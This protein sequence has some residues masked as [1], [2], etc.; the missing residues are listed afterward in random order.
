[1][2]EGKNNK[3]KIAITTVIVALIS[4]G[5]GFF[6]G[7]Q[8]QKS[9]RPTGFSNRT[10]EGVPSGSGIPGG[11]RMGGRGDQPVSGEITSIDDESITVKTQDG[12]SKIITISSSTKINIAKEGAISD[13]AEG[14]TVMIIGIT[15]TDGTVSATSVTTGAEGYMPSNS[16]AL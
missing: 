7:I 4:L 13:L 9:Q 12:G 10:Q 14:D 16:K 8:Y 3:K 6:G 2:Q 11:D 15:N 1:M 5:I